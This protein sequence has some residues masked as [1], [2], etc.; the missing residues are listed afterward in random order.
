MVAWTAMRTAVERGAGI[1]SHARAAAPA[2]LLA[3]A[4]VVLLGTAVFRGDSPLWAHVEPRVARA[5]ADRAFRRRRE[6]DGQALF[7]LFLADRWLRR[8]D[9]G[10]A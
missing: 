4:A 8:F 2:G 9:L 7:R 10:G 1:S 3:V 6:E 5:V